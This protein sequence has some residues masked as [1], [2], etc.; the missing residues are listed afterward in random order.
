MSIAV[1][2]AK[3]DDAPVISRIGRASF[4]DAFGSFFHSQQDLAD[5]LERTYANPKISSSIGKPNNLL[6][7]A[8]WEGEAAGF[9]KMR[10]HSPHEQVAEERVSELQKLYVLKPFHGKGIA[11]ALLNEVIATA[12]QLN[13]A[14]LWLDVLKQNARAIRFYEKNGFARKGVHQFLI[15]SQLFYYDVMAL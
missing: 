10:R 9:A 6:F 13:S 5:Y 8:N 11:Q 4:S 2:I 7:T 14:Y 1:H 12:K 15:G 3:Q